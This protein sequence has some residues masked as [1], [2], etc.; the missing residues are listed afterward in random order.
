MNW[1]K[2]QDLQQSKLFTISQIAKT[3]NGKIDGNPNLTILGVCDLKNSSVNHL[4]YI[5][6]NKYEKLFHKSNK[7]LRLSQWQNQ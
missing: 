6:S 1:V 2:P 4:S 5:V 3:V 7:Y